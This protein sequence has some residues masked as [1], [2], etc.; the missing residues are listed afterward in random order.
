MSR[1]KNLIFIFIIIIFTIGL[2]V[3]SNHIYEDIKKAKILVIENTVT[4]AKHI[5]KLLVPEKKSEENS[6]I[7]NIFF[8]QI[9]SV[10]KQI[11]DT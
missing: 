2:S 3:F 7:Q 8:Y 10:L 6:N 9:K 4:V 1:R 11:E 5:F